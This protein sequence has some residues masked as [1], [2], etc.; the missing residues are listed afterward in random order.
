[1]SKLLDKLENSRFG[2]LLARVE[3]GQTVTD[4]DLDRLTLL[5]HLDTVCLGQI[6]LA[7]AVRFQEEQDARTE[8]LLLHLQQQLYPDRP[9]TNELMLSKAE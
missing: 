8:R 7:E 9:T 6:A 2:E 5:Q 4:K 3:Q 1:M